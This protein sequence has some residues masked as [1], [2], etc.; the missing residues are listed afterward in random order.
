MNKA[1]CVFCRIA[2]GEIP[3]MKIWENENFLAFLDIRPYAK[4]HL[5]VVPKSHSDWVWDM[6]D[7][8]YIEFM[9]RV[10]YLANVLR[11]AFDTEWVEEIIAG[12]GISHSHIH[13]LPRKKNDGLGEVPTKPL[14]I[15][16]SEREMEEIAE[17]IIKEIR[18]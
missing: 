5:L 15:K 13:L 8:E 9:K 17:K 18:K 16:P 2:K 11:K 14:T 1:D 12:V 6:N 4:G 3:S 10:K 7:K